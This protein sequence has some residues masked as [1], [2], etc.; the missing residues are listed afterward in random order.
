MSVLDDLREA[1]YKNDL[2]EVYDIFLMNIGKEL[3]VSLKARD[4]LL[5]LYP[6]LEDFI[7]PSNAFFAQTFFDSINKEGLREYAMTI[8]G[9]WYCGKTGG[10]VGPNQSGRCKIEHDG[11]M[12]ADFCEE[13]PELLNYIDREIALYGF[14]IY[15]EKNYIEIELMGETIVSR[16]NEGS[17]EY[18]YSIFEFNFDYGKDYFSFHFSR[19]AD[20]AIKLMIKSLRETL[21]D[22][23][24]KVLSGELS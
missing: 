11:L 2:H 20:R 1:Q 22:I 15:P 7:K 8:L 13:Y 4:H 18:M 16:D 19:I 9:L 3:L 24:E 5:S 17:P 23:G 6:H 21:V 14:A 12:L 10:L